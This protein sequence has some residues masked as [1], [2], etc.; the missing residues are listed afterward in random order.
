MPEIFLESTTQENAFILC[1]EVISSGLIF[2]PSTE[3]YLVKDQATRRTVGL[4][5]YRWKSSSV[6]FKN[7]YIKPQWRGMGFFKKIMDAGIA[8][9]R[10]RGMKYID[11]NATQMA[12]REWLIRGA[13][14]RK[15]YKSGITGVRIY[16]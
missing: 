15:E 4:C 13:E 10:E 16:L 6:T 8:T 1:P 9:A 11:A 14:V 3:L 5:G 12:I 7:D 2:S